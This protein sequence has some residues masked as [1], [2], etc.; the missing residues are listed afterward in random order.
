M[1]DSLSVILFLVIP[2]AVLR[3]GERQVWRGEDTGAEVARHVHG[4][5]SD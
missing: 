5:C 1:E 2:E 3:L 4:H